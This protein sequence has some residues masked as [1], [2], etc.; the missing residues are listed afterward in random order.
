MGL[1]RLIKQIKKNIS[2]YNINKL[3][4]NITITDKNQIELHLALVSKQDILNRK[5]FCKD[6]L[7]LISNLDDESIATIDKMLSKV[8]FSKHLKDNKVIITISDNDLQ[9]INRVKNEFYN[10]IFQLNNDHF[11]YKNYHLPINHFEPSVL[12]FKHGLDTLK[13]LE[14]SKN[15]IDV[16]GFIGDSAIVLT[17]YTTKYVYSFEP[18]TINYNLM[19]KTIALNNSKNII[20][21]K[22]GLGSKPEKLI[23]NYNT[24][25]SWIGKPCTDK[26]ES[27]EISTLD[28]F[29]KKHNL[30]IGLIK[31][32]IEGFEQEF[33]KGAQETIKQQHPILLISIYHNLDD[34][35]F[36]K[37][38]IESWNLGYTFKV[39]V[40]SLDPLFA[41]ILLIAEVTSLN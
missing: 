1:R 33:L 12:Y 38:I 10:K 28:I 22:K 41:E 20:P 15:I 37:P 18:S 34:F 30:A 31:V 35:F 3:L 40:P 36:I 6:Y 32:D 39:Y 24:S 4:N 7:K 23:L 16:G 2:K 14:N 19:L 29:V 9:I 21:V 8:Y 17:E 26:T 13:N 27:I 11:V 25:G 5:T